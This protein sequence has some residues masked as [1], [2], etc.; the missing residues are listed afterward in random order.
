MSGYAKNEFIRDKIEMA[1]DKINLFYAQPFINYR[2]R[3]K[4]TKEL[5]TEIVAE[6]VLNHLDLF[7]SIQPI[8]RESSYKTKGHDGIPGNLGSNRE[9]ELIAI[10]MYRQGTLPIVG[11][12]IDYQTPLKSKLKDEA[13][14]IDLLAYNGKTLRIL[15]L[16]RPDSKETML[17]CVLEGLTYLKTVNKN[18][19]LSDFSLSKSAKIV[20]NPFVAYNSKQRVEMREDRPYLKKLMAETHI[21]PL[22]YV[23]E[24]I[25]F[26]VI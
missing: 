12:I 2:G 11:E 20:A 18:K 24:N 19:L 17:R 4:D 14:K 16:K 10:A 5:Y 25:P 22:Y 13:G 21:A 3:T 23:G 15:E 1:A 26:D 8:T 6:W 7:Q 9:E